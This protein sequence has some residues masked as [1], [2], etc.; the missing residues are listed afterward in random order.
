VTDGPAGFAE[1]RPLGRFHELAG[2][3]CW[4]KRGE[5]VVVGLRLDARHEN[6]VPSAHGGLLMTLVDTAMTLAAN[7]AAPKGQYAVTQSISADF[8]APARAGDWV[9][10]EVEVLRAGR[11]TIALDCRVRKDGA[12]GKLL[13]RASGTF[14]VIA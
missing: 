11:T 1:M 12:D 3:F 9:E 14:H 10:A 5:S 8:L 2:P 13:L 7:R 6:A 4:M